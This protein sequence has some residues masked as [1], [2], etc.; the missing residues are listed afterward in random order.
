MREF[1]PVLLL[2][3]EN[4]K[5]PSE[6]VT[7]TGLL[8]ANTVAPASGFLSALPRTW[9]FKGILTRNIQATKDH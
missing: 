4:S 5:T 2:G 6:S 9:P 3:L 7:P 8:L 1:Y